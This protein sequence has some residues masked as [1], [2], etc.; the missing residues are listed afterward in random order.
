MYLYTADPEVLR[1]YDEICA[2]SRRPWD[3]VYYLALSI[4]GTPSAFFGTGDF[5]RHYRACAY[6]SR[7]RVKAVPINGILIPVDWFAEQAVQKAVNLMDS[8]PEDAYYDIDLR[9]N[10]ND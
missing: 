1:K 10:T 2:N 8:L 9:E 4:C 7:E 6:Y 5:W 3:A